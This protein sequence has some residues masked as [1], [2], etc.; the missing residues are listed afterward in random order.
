M[1]KFNGFGGGGG[2]SMQ[3]MMRQAQKMQEQMQKA[4][5]ELENAEVQGVSG[6]GMVTVT[7]SGKK[8]ILG[9]A[10][11][12]EAMDPDDCEMLEDLIVAATNEA[13]DKAEEL[14]KQLLP[15]AGMM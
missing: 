13:F 10:I 14:E 11:K 3:A 12:P 5:E 7:M 9:I 8:R 4:K 1:G 6:G 2:N 15:F